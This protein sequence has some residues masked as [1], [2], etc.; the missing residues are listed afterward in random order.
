MMK[1]APD[2]GVAEWLKEHDQ[3]AALSVLV[4]AELADGVESLPQGKRRAALARK[5]DF[6]CEDYADQILVFDE[7]CAWE[8][9]RYLRLM[10]EAGLSP[11]LLDSQIAATAR[12]WGLTVVTR[13]ASDFP[14]MEVVNPFSP[15]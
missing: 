10:R 9:A 2:S 3:E 11:P 15:Q 4:L 1:P 13:N 12:V 6:L 7:A 5:L 8:W 14:L